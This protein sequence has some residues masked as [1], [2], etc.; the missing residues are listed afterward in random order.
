MAI[1]SLNKIPIPKFL[2][3][4]NG[5]YLLTFLKWLVGLEYLIVDIAKKYGKSAAQI[6]IRFQV[7]RDVVVIPKSVNPERIKQNFDVSDC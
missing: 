2:I 1:P 4:I 3:L 5:I 6:L 7:D